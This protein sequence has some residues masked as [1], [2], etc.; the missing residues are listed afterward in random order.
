VNISLPPLDFLHQNY[1]PERLG[2]ALMINVPYMFMKA[3]KLV[4]P[5]ID[6]NTRDKVL[7]RVAELLPPTWETVSADVHRFL[8]PVSC[9][10]DPSAECTC[11]S[12][13]WTTRTCRKRCAGR[14][15][16]ASSQ[17]SL[18]G[19]CLWF[20]SRTTSNSL[21]QFNHTHWW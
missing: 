17:I 5:F 16:K 8:L 21:C 14:W 12:F 9:P 1:Y 15:T 3:W 11:S 18:A 7:I 19:R 4:Y 20:P 13:S 10:D 2:K 6:N